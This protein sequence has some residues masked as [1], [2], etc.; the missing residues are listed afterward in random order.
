MSRGAKSLVISGDADSETRKMWIEI[1]TES[2]RERPMRR[3]YQITGWALLVAI[4]VLSFVPPNSR[5]E[6]G[7]PHS[8]EHLALF[9]PT[10][11]AFA[12]GYAPRYFLQLFALMIFTVAV[13]LGQMW[14]PGR[15]ARLSDFL[16]NVL[17]LCLGVGLGFLLGPTRSPHGGS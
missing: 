7:A 6:T 4:T 8:L 15:H 3:I 9:V 11:L 10:G 16:I 2:Y 12:L 5:P 17:G 13:E 1:K 14:V